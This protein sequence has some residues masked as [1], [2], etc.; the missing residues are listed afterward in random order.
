MSWEFRITKSAAK[1]LKR[2]PSVNR[3]R[4]ERKIDLLSDNPL[5]GNVKKL[6]GREGYRSRVGDY[7]VLFA[8]DKKKKVITILSVKH[9]RDAYKY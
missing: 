5:G 8:L 6:S 9:R 1:E 7:R 3:E 4:I 2:T